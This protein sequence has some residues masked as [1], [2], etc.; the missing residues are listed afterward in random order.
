M[1]VEIT[2]QEVAEL[3]KQIQKREEF[4]EIIRLNVQSTIFITPFLAEKMS[5]EKALQR[6][7][8]SVHGSSPV[9]PFGESTHL[10]SA[11]ENIF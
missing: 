9:K 2:V 11:R 4:F 3:F 6:S 5:D 1:N 8:E 7:L 10:S